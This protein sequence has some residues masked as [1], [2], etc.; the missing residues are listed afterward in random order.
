MP[1]R[2]PRPVPSRTD[3]TRPQP[4]ANGT[5][6]TGGTFSATGSHVG[7]EPADGPAAQWQA[8]TI[9]ITARRPDDLMVADI[10]LTNLH[11]V[12]GVSPTLRRR[13]ASRPATL[14]LE[15]PPQS[16]GEEA[17]LDRTLPEVDAD[18]AQSYPDGNGKNAST[19]QAETAPAPGATRIRMAGPTRLAFIM[20]D[21]VTSIPFTLESILTACR[22]WPMRRTLTAKPASNEFVAT[23][24]GIVGSGLVTSGAVASGTASS[25]AAASG[26]GSA[27]QSVTPGRDPGHT[28]GPAGEGPST[29]VSVGPYRP[30]RQVTAIEMPYRLVLSPVGE[31]GWRHRT[32]ADALQGRHE[33]WHT[34]LAPTN[35][36]GSDDGPTNVRAIWSEDYGRPDLAEIVNLLA[37]FR[38]PLDA[39][40][41]DLLVRLTAGFTERRA[42]NQLY[43]PQPL[44][45]RRLIL[46]ALGGWFDASGTWTQRPAGIDLEHWQHRMSLGRDHYVRVVYAGFLMPFGHAASLI[47]VTERKFE[48]VNSRTPL[49]QRVARLRQRF[50]IV[51]REPVKTFNG[52]RHVSGGHAFPFTSVE[53]LT[54][55]TPNLKAPDDPACR[56]SEAGGFLYASPS[57]QEGLAHREAFWPITNADGRDLHFHLAAI[58]RDGHRTTFALPLMFVAGRANTGTG[59]KG[60]QTAPFIDM[61]RAGYN[62]EGDLRRQATFGGDS[63]CFAPPDNG[64]AGDPRLPT[65]TMR[66]R[67]GKVTAASTT[68]LNAYPEVQDARVALRAVQRIL[69]R[70]DAVVSVQYDPVYAAEGFGAGNTGELFLRLMHPTP[71]WNVSFGPSP[72]A[73]RTDAVGAI[74]SPSMQITGLS[75]RIGMAADLAA[76]QQNRFNPASFFNDARILGGIRLEDLI[77]SVTSGLSGA[78]VPKFTTRDLP[79]SGSLPARSEARYDWST[80]IARS[81]PLGIVLPRADGQTASAFQLSAVTTARAGAGGSASSVIT[82]TMKN[83]C[84]NLWGFI[85]L[86][87]NGLT[88][89]S[90]DGRKPAVTVDMHRSK[91][92]M[93]GGPLNFVNKLREFIPSEGFSDPSAIQVTPSG[94]AAG[95][96]LTIPRVQVGVLALSGVSLGA[97]FELPFDTAPMSVAFNFGKREDPFSLTISLLGGGG[98]LLIGVGTDGVREIEAA[99]EAQARLSIDL[100]V[101]SGSV[102]ISL[103]IYFHWLTGNDGDGAVELSGYVRLHGELD[104]M[105]IVSMSLTFNLQLG[106]K[107]QG[108]SLVIFGEASVTVEI[109][110]LV[111]SGEV[112]VRCRREFKNPEADPTFAQLVPGLSTWESYCLAFAAE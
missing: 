53:L 57:V 24:P 16:F 63:I 28:L 44:L 58:D 101:A 55:V 32:R 73:S 59:R 85:V 82:A 112:I 37:P 71:S 94:I 105:C 77:E 102:E 21:T 68:L 8:A 88:F 67:A 83:F 20:P 9:R 110:V 92:V 27:T 33:L 3:T 96:A 95:Y 84:V 26:I 64:A 14:V 31:V 45:S 78:N 29:A 70:D 106:I 49:A 52:A 60:A 10:W 35:L 51:V 47:K 86:R 98:F 54:R 23:T 2:K 6:G 107:K 40:D 5:S 30:D 69:S 66:F 104:V 108:G 34:R 11:V 61:L 65:E 15:L 46:S 19:S 80:V 56:V 103:G 100:G 89:T 87:F 7:V 72:N 90:T 76:V 43:V 93:F 4:V 25:G 79:A 39:L 18:A 50:F 99:I 22:T 109:E 91:A 38:M 62:A 1:A 97:R 41:R 75:R 81:D 36:L 48:P 13:E 17:L 74:A 12:T 42:G 111:F